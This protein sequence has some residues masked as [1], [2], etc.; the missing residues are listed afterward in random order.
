MD[1]TTKSAFSPKTRRSWGRGPKCS[2]LLTRGCSEY[3]YPFQSMQ[4]LVADRRSLERK[5][6][7]N[8]CSN[9]WQCARAENEVDSG[10][11]CRGGNNRV[12]SCAESAIQKFWR[13]MM[14]IR[15]SSPHQ[16]RDLSQS[17]IDAPLIGIHIRLNGATASL[18]CNELLRG[19]LVDHPI[20]PIRCYCS[21]ETVNLLC[22]PLH[23]PTFLFSVHPHRSHSAQ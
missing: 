14:T 8:K 21:I 23:L 17:P 12:G 6:E 16:T 15:L 9:C 10:S 13:E 1:V 20:A 2:G 3:G 22:A 18:A 4:Q 7:G 5:R 19:T 11:Q